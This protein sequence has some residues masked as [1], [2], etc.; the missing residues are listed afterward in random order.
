M[1]C[2]HMIEYT[3]IQVVYA[4]YTSNQSTRSPAYNV[5]PRIHNISMN[6]CSRCAHHGIV[7][8]S[9]ATSAFYAEQVNM[10]A[11]SVFEH[12]QV[13]CV[14]MAMTRF[15][16]PKPPP[17]L[18]FME[19]D[20]S[21]FSIGDT[22]CNKKVGWRLHHFLQPSLLVLLLS[23]GYGVFSVDADWRMVHPLPFQFLAGHDVVGLQDHAPSGHYLNIGLM[24]VRSTNATR[25]AWRRIA[26]RS[27]LGWDQSIANEELAAS[28]ASCCSSNAWLLKAFKQNKKIHA[29]K[30]SSVGNRT[31]GVKP[32]TNV[33]SPPN[34]LSYRN[35]RTND[36]NFNNLH[37]QHT[38]C[39]TKCPETLV[40]S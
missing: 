1:S 12:S 29:Y 28:R 22:F 14:C 31:C 21:N 33:L 23:S 5:L 10:L 30:N 16:I 6:A 3:S 38:R 36:L 20:D 40:T 26:N 25:F 18:E 35:W 39:T 13:P 4:L 19:F 7:F 8:A 34:N 27:H 15:S 32:N 24:Y 37:R 2:C 17:F 11:K 9:F